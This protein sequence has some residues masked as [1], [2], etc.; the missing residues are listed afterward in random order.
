MGNSS[1][2]QTTDIELPPTIHDGD[3]P[4]GVTAD[5][6]SQVSVQTWSNAIEQYKDEKHTSM[7]QEGDGPF[8]IFKIIKV[9]DVNLM[10]GSFKIVMKTTQLFK[11][12]DCTDE[13]KF[14]IPTMIYGEKIDD[15]NGHYSLNSELG[16]I[17]SPSR[18][19]VDIEAGDEEVE[20]KIQDNKANYYFDRRVITISQRYDQDFFPFDYHELMIPITYLGATDPAIQPPKVIHLCYENE[21]T[22]SSSDWSL[23]GL[24]LIVNQNYSDHQKHSAFKIK[25]L[26]SRKYSKHVIN[27]YIPSVLIVIGTAA[28]RYI[29]V[30]SEYGAIA[31]SIALLS[32]QLTLLRRILEVTN[33]PP[34]L[35]MMAILMVIN[36]AFILIITFAAFFSDQFYVDLI[37]IGTVTLILTTIGWMATKQIK[38]RI[39][40]KNYGR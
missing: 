22:H 40:S 31:F 23:Q 25:I 13:L 4:I 36:S 33:Q 17:V 20:S 21:F 2:S 34:R 38:S 30:F 37:M 24:K 14:Y 3:D 26:I 10:E 7:N 18:K 9:S 29:K 35:P 11:N 27:L 5:E 28:V 19:V 1:N 6:P 12:D 15:L 39:A 32:L 8:V 16:E